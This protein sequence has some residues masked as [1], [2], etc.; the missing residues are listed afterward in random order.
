[1][2]GIEIPQD[3]LTA[4]HDLSQVIHRRKIRQQVVTDGDAMLRVIEWIRQYQQRIPQPQDAQ[5]L[6]FHFRLHI[7]DKWFVLLVSIQ[8]LQDGS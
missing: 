5:V 1:M 6:L 8:V 3:L 4:L 2:Q 7:A